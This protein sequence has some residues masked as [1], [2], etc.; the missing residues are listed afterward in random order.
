MRVLALVL[1]LTA[2]TTAAALAQAYPSA[3]EPPRSTDP[4]TLR[5]AAVSRE[6]HEG[7]SCARTRRGGGR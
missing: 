5:A 6:V 4:A 7:V 3:T 2:T 1:A